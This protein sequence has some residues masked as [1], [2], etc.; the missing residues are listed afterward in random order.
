MGIKD[1]TKERKEEGNKGVR[2]LEKKW[3]ND[4]ASKWRVREKSKE[5]RVPRQNQL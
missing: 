4:A 3:V 5:E 2:E 1:I